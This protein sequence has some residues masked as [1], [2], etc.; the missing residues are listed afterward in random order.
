MRRRF[1]LITN[2]GAGLTGSPLVDGVANALLRRGAELTLTQPADADTARS[3]AREAAASG[4]FDAILAAGGDGT[5][6]QVAA[7]LIGTETPLGIIPVGTGNVLAHEIGVSPQAR[8]I[9]DMLLGGPVIDAVCARANDEPFLLMA[10]AGFDGR[11]I[12]ALDHKLKS[13]VGKA[14]Y[15]GPMLGTLVLHPLDKLTV[16]VDGTPHEASW[17]VISNA[18]HY[19]GNFVMARGTG[20][21]ERG[22]QAILFKAENR[23]VLVSQLMALAMGHLDERCARHG[24]VEMLPCMRATIS[25]QNPVPT[26]IDGDAFGPT[27]LEV[28]AGAA[29]LRLI[30]PSASAAAHGV[31]H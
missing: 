25:A 23:A 12:A 13:H 9:V 17:A 8:A 27:P 19:G 18:R 15:A 10:G 16:T 22:L 1:Y 3:Q 7:S 28:E 26:Q 29:D 4:R 2:P 6:R 11:V 21:R 5:I 24:D 31:A 20:I 30:V 14:A